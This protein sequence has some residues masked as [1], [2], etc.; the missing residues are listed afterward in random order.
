MKHKILNSQ[1]GFTLAELLVA[2]SLFVIVVG[3]SL[4]ALISIFDANNRA[5]ATKTVVDNLNLSIENLVRTVRFGEYYYCGADSGL[6]SVYDCPSGND[7]LSVTFQNVRKIYRLCGNQ[8]KKS[9]DSTIAINC[10]DT[11]MQA[12]TSADTVIE[13][14]RFYVFGSQLNPNAEQPYIIAVIKGYVGNKPTVKS[15]FLIQTT[16]SQR[17]LDF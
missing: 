4:G 12:I 17:T 8:I 2:V 7:T 5:R 11:G 14:L 13:Y 16:I 15:S 10:N 6:S 1:K 3:I 9:E